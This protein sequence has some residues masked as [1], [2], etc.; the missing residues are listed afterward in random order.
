MRDE[1]LSFRVFRCER[2]CFHLTWGHLTLH[3]SRSEF[4]ALARA[5]LAA[6]EREGCESALLGSGVCDRT[7]TSI[8]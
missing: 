7:C 6:L 4:L 5:I 2:G 8:H 3:F 1:V